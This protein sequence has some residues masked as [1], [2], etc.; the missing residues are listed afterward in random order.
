METAANRAWWEANVDASEATEQRR[1]AADLAVSDLLADADAYA[2]VR[3]A[4]ASRDVEADPI[5][6]RAL[7]VLA[8]AFVHH[9]VPADLRRRQIDL[10][11]AIE[12]RFAR[13]RSTIDGEE[14]DDNAIA[15]QLEEAFGSLVDQADS[16]ARLGDRLFAPGAALRWDHLVEHATGVA[17]SPAVLERSLR[18]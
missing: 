6:A 16:G 18:P 7:T 3:D 14:V 11:T 9:Q 15:S 5:V 13:H 10:Q 2:E 4:R 1:A 12:S 8:Q 17:L